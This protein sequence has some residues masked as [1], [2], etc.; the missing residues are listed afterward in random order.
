[1]NHPKRL[2]SNLCALAVGTSFAA[3]MNSSQTR[4]AAPAPAATSQAVAQVPVE[5]SAQEQTSTG[6]AAQDAYAGTGPTGTGTGATGT[7]D[8]AQSN[9]PQTWG[10]GPAQPNSPPMGITNTMGGMDVSG[11]NDA[12]LA[13]VIHAMNDGEIQEAQLAESKASAASVKRYAQHLLSAHRDMMNKNSALLARLQII[14]SDNAVS[15]QIK[16]DSQNEMSTLQSMR[17]KDFDRDYV[18]AQVRNHN[19]ALELVDRVARLVKNA[20]FRAQLQSDRTRIESHLRDA[21]RLQESLQK[22]STN[23]QPPTWH[24]QTPPGGRRSVPNTL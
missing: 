1:M 24:D 9:A 15:N 2:L 19:K 3:C 20:E 13:A 23:A 17:G 21:E 11:L 10:A 5:P 18:D 12:Q 14:P 6:T 16:S 4:A 7:M 22:G 8:E